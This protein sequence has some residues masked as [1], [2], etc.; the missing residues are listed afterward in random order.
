MI[1]VLGRRSEIEA[2]LNNLQVTRAKEDE[3]VRSAPPARPATPAQQPN[4]AQQAAATAQAAAKLPDVAAKDTAT[5]KVMPPAAVP[6]APMV[7]SPYIF[8]PNQEYYVALVMEKIDPAYVNEAN[9]S[10]ANSP[11]KNFNGQPVEP[12]KL[13]VK[14]G[15]WLLLLKSPAFKSDSEALAYIN[16]IKPVASKEILTWLDAARYSYI[17]I[18]ESSL[19]ALQ[20]D[21]N[22]ELYKK[23]L[24]QQYPGQF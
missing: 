14:D 4:A 6:G 5:N 2:Y 9:Y 22:L 13:K 1:E 12:T 7:V 11:R 24:Q 20:Q 23:A 17:I 3:V 8:P 21:S 10:F 16:Y 19:Q 15:L 18:N